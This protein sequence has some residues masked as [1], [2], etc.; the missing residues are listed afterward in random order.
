MFEIALE[1]CQDN[2]PGKFLNVFVGITEKLPTF[3]RVVGSVDGL[4]AIEKYYPW[5]FFKEFSDKTIRE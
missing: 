3:V 5:D 4:E 1:E 2:I